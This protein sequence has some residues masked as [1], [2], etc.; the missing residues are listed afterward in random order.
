MLRRLGLALALTLSLFSVATAQ[1]LGMFRWQSAPFCNVLTLAVTANGPTYRLEGTDDQ[2]GGAVQASAIGIAFANVDGSIGIGL[3]VVA[4]P[5]GAPV[6]LDA[7]IST[8]AGLSGTWRDN[9]A[10]IQWGQSAGT[11]S[12]CS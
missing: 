2:C 7:T 10:R 8:A 3:T 4:T 6:H 9:A 12:V 5:G 1:P 11:R